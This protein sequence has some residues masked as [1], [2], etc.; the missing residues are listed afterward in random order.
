[1]SLLI[2]VTFFSSKKQIKRAVMVNLKT[3]FTLSAKCGLIS[4]Q[5]DF[6]KCLVKDGAN[7]QGNMLTPN[8]WEVPSTP[9]HSWHRLVLESKISIW[10][11]LLLIYHPEKYWEND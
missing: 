4:V 1:M 2:M 8:I 7:K 5:Q 9:L 10:F 6:N 11:P 3:M